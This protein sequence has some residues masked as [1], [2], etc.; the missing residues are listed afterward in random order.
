MLEISND[1]VRGQYELLN[2][3]DGKASALLSFNGIFL[4]VLSIW[5]GYVPLNYL[6]LALDAVFILL[7]AS[8][9]LLL[10]V[11]WLRWSTLS[12][13]V[14]ELD[15]VRRSRTK[16]Y[17]RAWTLAQLSVAAVILISI[18]HMAGTAL[19]STGTCGETCAWIYG[20]EV[21]GNV[22]YAAP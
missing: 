15:A 4:A 12:E 1:S 11:I 17:Q 21:F 10:S 16:R 14:A 19:Q 9:S 7:L 8:S 18:A 2:I 5:L 20:P 6:H 13:T 22:D 3:L